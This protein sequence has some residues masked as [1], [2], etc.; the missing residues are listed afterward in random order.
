VATTLIVQL[1]GYDDI[2]QACIRGEAIHKPC[3]RCAKCMRKE[4]LRDTIVYGSV[5]EEILNHFMNQAIGKTV[6]TNDT[7][8]LQNVM[9]YIASHYKGNNPYMQLFKKRMGV[10]RINVDWFEKWYP[11]SIEIVA[12][13]YREYVKQQ[14]EKY[15]GVMTKQE[16]I[17]LENWNVESFIS[18][19]EYDRITK[20]LMALFN[21]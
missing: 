1:T 11:P 15:V 8:Y 14:I 17:L 3:M 19:E 21:K 12:S 7:V 16:Q 18:R 20:E 13:P 2:A 10:D 4:M 5:R 6:M 9:M